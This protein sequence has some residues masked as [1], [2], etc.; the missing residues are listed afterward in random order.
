MSISRQHQLVGFSDQLLQLF[1]AQLVLML[2]PQMT[3]HVVASRTAPIALRHRT[4]RPEVLVLDSIMEH[5]PLGALEQ[6][7][8]AR[9]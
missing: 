2:C 1:G 7:L 5:A 9:K 3:F 4:F 8:A 6:P